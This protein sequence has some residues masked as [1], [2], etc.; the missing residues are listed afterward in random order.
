MVISQIPSS[1]LQLLL[2]GEDLAI[3]TRLDVK[4]TFCN[5]CMFCRTSPAERRTVHI[6]EDHTDLASLQQA[7]P[8]ISEEST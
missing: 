5:I 4:H 1:V 6:D 8:T 2:D 3:M 7:L